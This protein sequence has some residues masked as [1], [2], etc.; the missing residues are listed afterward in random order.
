MIRGQHE[1]FRENLNALIEFIFLFWNPFN[2]WDEIARD[3]NATAKQNGKIGRLN[4][5]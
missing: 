4:S 5:P 1:S 3:K 2:S